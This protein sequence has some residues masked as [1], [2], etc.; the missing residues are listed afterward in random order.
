MLEKSN[1]K[2][3]KNFP[4]RR[5]RHF[6][7]GKHLKTEMT[8]IKERSGI[9]YGLSGRHK[10]RGL[11]FSTITSPAKAGKHMNMASENFLA[12]TPSG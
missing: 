11:N 7:G 5:K 6:S 12:C 1:G 3:G 2:R 10:M 8:S 4:P 9:F